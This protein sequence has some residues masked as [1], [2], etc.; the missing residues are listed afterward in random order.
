MPPI[1]PVA[2]CCRPIRP[3]SLHWPTGASVCASLRHA[4]ITRALQRA[5]AGRGS[6]N[7]KRVLRL[8]P[9]PS[10]SAVPPIAPVASCCRP[11]L[12]HGSHCRP[13]EMWCLSSDALTPHTCWRRNLRVGI[14]VLSC[15]KVAVCLLVAE[16]EPLSCEQH[17]IVNRID[18]AIDVAPRTRGKVGHETRTYSYKLTLILS[19]PTGSYLTPSILTQAATIVQTIM[20]SRLLHNPIPKT[21]T[22]S[23]ETALCT[24]LCDDNPTYCQW[25]LGPHQDQLCPGVHTTPEASK[26]FIAC[27]GQ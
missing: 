22:K 4:A 3:H 20:Q 15:L 14:E 17:I 13:R 9:D 8:A 11:I 12:P 5:R 16:E 25:G 19:R 21:S 2:S 27:G 7:S 18:S 1:A 23:S 24:F 26:N 6:S 10:R